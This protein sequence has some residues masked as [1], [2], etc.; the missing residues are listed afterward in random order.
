MRLLDRRELPGFAPYLLPRTRAALE[1]G[2]TAV[3]A[4]G[5]VCGRSAYGAAAF[6]LAGDRA[7]MTDLF[8]DAA[9]RR[10]GTA[11]RLLTELTLR[12]A[13]AG[14]VRLDA[15]YVLAGPECAA[16]DALLL[17]RGFTPPVRR[18]R[19]FRADS[20]DYRDDR[21]LGRAFRPGYR[22]PEGVTEFSALP[23]AALEELEHAADIPETLSWPVL[24]DAADSSLCV[25][26]VQEGRAAAYLLAA[27]S[28]D[29]G[30]ALLSA[31]RRTGAP[32]WAFTALLTELVN[33]CYYRMGGDFPFYFSALTPRVERLALRLMGERF[34]DYEEHTCSLA[35][36]GKART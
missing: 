18:S 5:A 16:M 17:G 30:C 26:L 33:R 2:D 14:A 23:R 29:G 27:P 25:A 28:E 8:V 22:T 34:A 32:A 36:P 31:V 7:V 4:V 24:R 10:R 20:A 3:T 9:V 13:D 19:V 11:G 15:D 12:A 21:W 35:V 6:R 1:R